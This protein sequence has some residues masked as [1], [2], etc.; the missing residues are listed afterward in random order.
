MVHCTIGSP[1]IIALHKQLEPK[2]KIRP[3]AHW[4]CPFLPEAVGT[5]AD[6]RS[7]LNFPD[8]GE[9]WFKY[10]SNVIANEYSSRHWAPAFQFHRGVPPLLKRG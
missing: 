1:R 8:H 6:G 2:S 4:A 10:A 9:I 3:H 7:D 5:S